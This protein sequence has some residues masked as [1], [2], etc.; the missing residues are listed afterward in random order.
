MK[1]WE[2]TLLAQHHPVLILVVRQRSED[3]TLGAHASSVLGFAVMACLT[4]LS[5]ALHCAYPGIF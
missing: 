2:R 3:E 1:P 5:A 4:R